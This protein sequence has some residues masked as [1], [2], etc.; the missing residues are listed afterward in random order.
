[1]KKKT[2]L[3]IAATILI[4]LAFYWVF[5]LVFYFD[6]TIDGP[7]IVDFSNDYILF[8]HNYLVPLQVFGI[9]ITLS[10]LAFRFYSKLKK[11]KIIGR[12]YLIL[13]MLST[14]P[15]WYLSICHLH[16]II[17]NFETIYKALWFISLETQ[18]CG[19][20]YEELW[21]YI[22]YWYSDSDTII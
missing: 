15:F 14:L 4:L 13:V 3:T 11:K 10:I 19:A 7:I 8:E 17:S 21:Q 16:S 22:L 18:I 20:A 9:T 5:W 12:K 6:A 2:I 1:M